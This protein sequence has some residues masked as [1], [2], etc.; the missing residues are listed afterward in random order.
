MLLFQVKFYGYKLKNNFK[1]IIEVKTEYKVLSINFNL[2]F[3]V[4]FK[5]IVK[6]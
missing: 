3:K 2:R 4:N 6:R 5:K 1:D